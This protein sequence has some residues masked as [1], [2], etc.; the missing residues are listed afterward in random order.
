MILYGNTEGTALKGA[1]KQY[2]SPALSVQG[3]EQCAVFPES[4]FQEV[5][6]DV[7]FYSEKILRLSGVGCFAD[8][9][10][11]LGYVRGRPSRC[12]EADR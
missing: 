10:H 11:R 4:F 5:S 7:Y 1:F 12:P 2:A 9:L 8:G 6:A 3:I